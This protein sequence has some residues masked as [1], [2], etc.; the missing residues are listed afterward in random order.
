MR[1][2]KER[3][4]AHSALFVAHSEATRRTIQS[5]FDPEK[6][7]EQMAPAEFA[8][9]SVKVTTLHELCGELLRYEISDTELLDRDAFESKQSQLLYA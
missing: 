9:Q 2:A 6:E 4:E 1:T 8:L 7:K 3:G 5:M